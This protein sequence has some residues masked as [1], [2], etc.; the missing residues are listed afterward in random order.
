MIH[1]H[2]ERVT[3]VP[4][5]KADEQI[6]ADLRPG[7]SFNARASFQAFG[8]R[9]FGSDFAGVAGCCEL[10]GNFPPRRE[11]ALELREQTT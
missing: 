8:E 9:Q 1:A 5:F 6:L 11:A 3:R 10:P 2:S 7:A 4:W